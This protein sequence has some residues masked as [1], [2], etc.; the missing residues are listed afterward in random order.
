[1]FH[2]HD[3]GKKGRLPK[4]NSKF[5]PENAGWKTILSWIV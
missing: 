3:Y 2:V 5:A 4:T 1:M